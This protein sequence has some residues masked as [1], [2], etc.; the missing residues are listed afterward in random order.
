MRW[1]QIEGWFAP[2][3]ARFVSAICNKITNGIV[4]ELGFFAGKSTAVMVPICIRNNNEYHAVDNCIGGCLSDP[5]TKAQR[6]RNMLEV[7]KENMKR[8]NLLGQFNIHKE[9]SAESS[10][11]FRDTSVDFCF[12]DASHVAKDVKRDIEAWWP[13]IK[14]GGILGGHDY[15]WGSVSGVV[16]AFAQSNGLKPVVDG[17][18]WMIVKQGEKV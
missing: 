8:L 6:S 13:K 7:F 5:A 14:C 9:D 1:D 4:V 2:N 18:C 3:D 15:T 12:I 16:D 10:A 11:M 17:N